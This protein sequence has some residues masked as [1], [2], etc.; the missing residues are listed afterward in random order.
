MI[1][2][3]ARELESRGLTRTGSS[4]SPML[5]SKQAQT[6]PAGSSTSSSHLRIPTEAGRAGDGWGSA[7]Q[8]EHAN[9]GNELDTILRAGEK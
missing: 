5:C 2:V 9:I 3:R 7:P 1:A 4:S 8:K 6:L